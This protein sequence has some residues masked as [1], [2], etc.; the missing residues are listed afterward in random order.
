M[1]T[2]LSH[3]I[4]EAMSRLEGIDPNCDKD[5]LLVVDD[6]Q[7][8]RE[9]LRMILS[10]QHHV[11][12]AESANE[13]LQIL[14]SQPVDAITID[15]NMPGTKG[16]QLMRH[17]RSEF[18]HVEVIIITGCSSVE[19]A[20]DGIRHGIFDYLTKPFDVA[21]VSTTL[22]RALARKQSREQLLGFLNGIAEVLGGDSSPDTA[23]G[24]LDADPTLQQRLRAALTDP[25]LVP[26][27][28]RERETADRTYRFLEALAESV[29]AKEPNRRGHARRVAFL[30]DLLASAS[31][32]ANVEELRMAAVLHDLGRIG[33]FSNA[34][35]RKSDGLRDDHAQHP[36]L[37]A[38]LVEPLGFPAQVTEA[39]RHHHHRY[40]GLGQS[41]D[42]RGD[43]LPFFARVIA[44][45]DHFDALTRAVDTDEALS[46]ADALGALRREAGSR[47]D[48][49]LVETLARIV[50][51]GVPLAEPEPLEER[52]VARARR[53]L[54]D[55]TLF[56]ESDR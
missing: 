1:R 18:P 16:D 40:D 26:V 15:L 28:E 23:L 50:S 31:G 3:R 56:V 45:A 51:S 33:R 12:S 6:E 25:V 2:K 48:P 49:Q 42:L 29:E 46:C 41:G 53:S 35:Q 54:L 38:T 5:T 34:G 21:L 14:R 55:A 43:A 37:G 11:L 10:P 24:R 9:S 52:E 17:V 36:T 7:G 39:I 32:A 20:V 13:A 4:G 30:S 8:P 27:G 22:R 44:V 19:T 47:F